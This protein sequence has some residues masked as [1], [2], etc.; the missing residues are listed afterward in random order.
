LIQAVTQNLAA[1]GT[2]KFVRNYPISRR[3]WRRRSFGSAHGGQLSPMLDV[4]IR[5][6][7]AISLNPSTDRA[8]KVR[9]FST[10]AT[11]CLL[12]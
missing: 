4:I 1:V 2:A 10:R 8:K 6:C 9:F 5:V 12:P 3:R 11:I 7:A